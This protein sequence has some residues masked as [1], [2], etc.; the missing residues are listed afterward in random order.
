MRRKPSNWA[1]LSLPHKYRVPLRHKRSLGYARDDDTRER[2]VSH[3]FS[4]FGAPLLQ[5]LLCWHVKALTQAPLTSRWESQ[6]NENTASP[7][8]V[9]SS[10]ARN[11]ACTRVKGR[12]SDEEQPKH[13]GDFIITS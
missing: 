8:I 13:L 10:E 3:S 6:L 11:L 4:F 7:R 1:I 12:V 5:G 2:T 9:I